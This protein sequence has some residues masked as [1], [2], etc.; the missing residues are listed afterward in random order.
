MHHPGSQ[1]RARARTDGAQSYIGDETT[2][3]P[4]AGYGSESVTL[5]LADRARALVGGTARLGGLVASRR[6]R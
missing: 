2:G 1:P 5:S 3:A 4:L 6:R